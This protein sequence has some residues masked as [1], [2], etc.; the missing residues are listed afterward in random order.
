MTAIIYF[1]EQLTISGYL[2]ACAVFIVG[3]SSVEFWW[4][5]LG[6]GLH[7]GGTAKRR[8]SHP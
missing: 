7:S 1:L 4:P 5:V 6:L 3:G 2:I 8:T